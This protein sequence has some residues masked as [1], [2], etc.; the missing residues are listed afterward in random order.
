MEIDLFRLAVTELSGP[1]SK[2]HT[3]FRSH[4][5]AGMFH[6]ALKNIYIYNKTP[7]SMTTSLECVGGAVYFNLPSS[8]L[9]IAWLVRGLVGTKLAG[10]V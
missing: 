3:L 7:F 2:A 5:S 9:K 4:F 6:K 10:G 1:V 8:H